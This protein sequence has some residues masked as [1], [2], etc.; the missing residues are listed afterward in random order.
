MSDTRYLG[1][2]WFEAR[3]VIEMFPEDETKQRQRAFGALIAL[4]TAS[5]LAKWVKGNPL[6]DAVTSRKLPP[7]IVMEDV[8]IPASNG[9]AWAYKFR[10]ESDPFPFGDPFY[11]GKKYREVLFRRL[12]ESAELD[13][14]PIHRFKWDNW[15]KSWRGWDALYKAVPWEWER[16][17]LTAGQGAALLDK[18]QAYMKNKGFVSRLKSN[19]YDSRGEVLRVWLDGKDHSKDSILSLPWPPLRI[20]PTLVF[21]WRRPGF[22]DYEKWK[23]IRDAK[24]TAALLEAAKGPGEY[25]RAGIDNKAAALLVELAEEVIINGMEELQALEDIS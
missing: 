17:L 9:S 25:L 2:H 7:G 14:K 13:E 21:S 22:Q 23:L 16:E 3:G 4:P 18:I 20:V 19:N 6:R 10:S 1:F 11:W 5:A 15:G 8:V 24:R 12:Q